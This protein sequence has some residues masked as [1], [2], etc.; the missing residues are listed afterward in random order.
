VSAQTDLGISL[1]TAGA[2]AP[3]PVTI[4]V[5]M[6]GP[7]ADDTVSVELM[8]TMAPEV[9]IYAAESL[10]FRVEETLVLGLGPAVVTL[11]EP[12]QYRNF[13]ST[14]VR[15]YRSGQRVRIAHRRLDSA[16]RMEGYIQYQACNDRMCFLPK[17]RPFGFGPGG[18]QTVAGPS[19]DT[20]QGDW[21][22]LAG[23]F[24]VKGSAAGYLSAKQ[25]LAFLRDPA[26]GIG[27]DA[28]EGK[29]WW[30]VALIVLVGGLLLNLTPCVLP[31]V[32]V[33]LA[34]IGAGAQARS[35]G[36]GLLAGTVYGAAMALAY[37]VAG[38]AVIVSGAAFGGVNAS[39]SFNI[40]VAI[41]FALLA[42]AM[43]D[44][45]HVDFSRFRGRVTPDA[46]QRGRLVAVFG[47]GALT[48]LLAGACVAPVVISVLV[49]ATSQYGQGNTAALAL[50][51]LLGVGMALPWPLAGAGIAALPKPGAWMVWVRNLM[52]VAILALAV[53]YGYTGVTL[54]RGPA[55]EDRVVEEDEDLP[56]LPWTP[57]LAQGL[58]EGLATGKPVFIDFWASWCKSCHAMEATTFRDPKVRAA[59]RDRFVLVKYQAEQPSREP[60]RSVIHHFDVQ[61]LPTYTVLG[62]KK[63]GGLE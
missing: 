37:G 42:L 46:V 56:A 15:V 20:A 57:D 27:Q 53:Y 36:A 55:P 28:L 62:E 11:P 13:D 63:A 3:E 18:G 5:A 17:K 60:A 58:S 52:G 49:Y 16:W 10:F 2:A 33:T 54:L 45:F 29:G 35:R 61:G 26:G 34:V 22:E 40:G 23:R 59:L 4:Q 44:V 30:L 47:L 19:G 14:V 1:G 43:F 31:L 7:T 8:L 25:F 32:P 51:L 12:T 21:S 6:R 48:A 50:P 38:A 41:V 24:A 39:A 9:H